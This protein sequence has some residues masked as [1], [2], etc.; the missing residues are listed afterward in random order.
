MGGLGCCRRTL[1]Y[2]YAPS[3]AG[4]SLPLA[5]MTRRDRG[6]DPVL[7]TSESSS[8]TTQPWSGSGS[9]PLQLGAPRA[10]EPDAVNLEAGAVTHES[11]HRPRTDTRTDFVNFLNRA[12]W[13][14]QPASGVVDNRGGVDPV[15]ALQQLRARVRTRH[16]SY[17]T[18]SSYADWVRRFLE[19]LAKQQGV[20]HPLVA[21]ESVRDYL[22]VS[23]STASPPR[24]PVL[25]R[26]V[27]RLRELLGVD[28]E[29][30]TRSV[31][32]KR[33]EHLPVV[34][35]MPETAALLGAMR[36]TARLM[37][38]LIYGGGLR[39][40]E[41]CNL[42]IK[43]VDFAQGLLFVR[44]GKGGK[45]RSTLLAEAG[46]RTARSA[47]PVRPCTCPS[48]LR[49]GERMPETLERKYR[50]RAESWRGSGHSRAT[51]SPRIHAPAWC[52]VIT[53]ATPWSRRR[54]RRRRSKRA[55]TSR[56]RYTRCDTPSRLTCC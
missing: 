14:R 36:G 7:D 22:T 32:A 2:R 41:C 5:F 27:F 33:G 40:S 46:A 42:R 49:S 43:D 56:C 15:A 54:S 34:L 17:R 16:Y 50:A 29:G 37:A 19:H 39:V 53:S 10:V 47:Q 21:A 48:R 52:G 8:A 23:R 31:R 13:H 28:L 24:G 45:D 3:L 12:D 44:G 30:L 9:S 35:S 18:E 20:A 1:S 55:S 6:T 25:L 26:A 4:L 51:R 38:G 11:Q